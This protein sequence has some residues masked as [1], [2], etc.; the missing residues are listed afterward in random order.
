MTTPKMILK[1]FRLEYSLNPNKAVSFDCPSF[2]EVLALI[3]PLLLCD[4]TVLLYALDENG[5]GHLL[6][7]VSLV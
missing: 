1:P 4:K 5:D 3:V 7:E 6:A 2:K